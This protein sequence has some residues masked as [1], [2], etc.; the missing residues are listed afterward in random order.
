M[1]VPDD[2][3]TALAAFLERIAAGTANPAEFQTHLAT[4]Y[5][6]SLTERVRHAVAKRFLGYA[7]P[8]GSAAEEG[9][10]L[11]AQAAK[12]RAPAG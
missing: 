4:H 6:D 5:A 2:Q 9:A 12:L 10:W 8:R 3:R 7:G 1:S 11:R